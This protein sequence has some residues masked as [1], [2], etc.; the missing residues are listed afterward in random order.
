MAICG[1]I[2]G[3][4]LRGFEKRLKIGEVRLKLR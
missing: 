2:S 3:S 4:S 1:K